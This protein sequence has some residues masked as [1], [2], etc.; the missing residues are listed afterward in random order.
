MLAQDN[1]TS[2]IVRA[3]RMVGGFRFGESYYPAGH[4]IVTAPGRRAVF[5]PEAFGGRYT[6]I[7][8]SD[9]DASVDQS[10]DAAQE[11]RA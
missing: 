9:D 10:F 7:P 1:L 5:S 6:V 11:A 3:V 2:E 4:V 8:S